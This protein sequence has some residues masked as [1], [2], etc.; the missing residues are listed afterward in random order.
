MSK[1]HEQDQA[2][3]DAQLVS[4]V[5]RGDQEAFAALVQR[6][7]NL[8][9][10]VAWRFGVKR[11]DIEDVVSDVLIKVY[12]NLHRYRP[13]FP[14][15]TWLYRL[16]ANHLVDLSRRARHEKGRSDLPE[17]L[18]DDAPGPA[19]DW[20]VRER[21]GLVREALQEIDPR[22]RDTLLLVY[23]EGM[24]VE[25]VAAALEI[26]EGTVKTRLMR[27]RQALKKI[28]SRRHPEHFGGTSG[29]S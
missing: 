15:S 25:D 21:S 29:L 9:A 12:R 10:G 28:L 17:Q 5:L 20:E 8:I 11:D 24:K 23:V 16:T 22:Y 19:Q 3:E 14:F 13:D 2:S 26:P 18:A 7:Q 4:S 27:G 6:Y 1:T